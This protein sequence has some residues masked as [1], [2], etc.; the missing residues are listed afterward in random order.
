MYIKAERMPFIFYPINK[1][2][3]LHLEG[4]HKKKKKEENPPISQDNTMITS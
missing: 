3:H 4:A 2:L 1:H